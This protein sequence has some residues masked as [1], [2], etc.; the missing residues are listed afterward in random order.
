MDR[1]TSGKFFRYLSE[2]EVYVQIY[3]EDKILL[4]SETT[5]ILIDKTEKRVCE[6]NL[7]THIC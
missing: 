7:L 4:E 5:E 2:E 6:I 1:Q 3:L